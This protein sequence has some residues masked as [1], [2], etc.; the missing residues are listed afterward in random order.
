MDEDMIIA[1]LMEDIKQAEYEYSNAEERLS[2]L[3]DQLE[4]KT[5]TYDLFKIDITHDAEDFDSISEYVTDANFRSTVSISVIKTYSQ[6]ITYKCKLY[7]WNHYYVS[8]S[9]NC[10]TKK[11]KLKIT[12]Q[13]DYNIRYMIYKQCVKNKLGNIF[14]NTVIGHDYDLIEILLDIENHP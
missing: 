14:N 5:K 12:K 7:I 3:Q 8:G 1:E 11:L 13:A 9:T 2:K 4:Q 6:K 10:E